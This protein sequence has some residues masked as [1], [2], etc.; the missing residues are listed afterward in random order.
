MIAGPTPSTIA[1]RL[2]RLPFGLFHLTLT[3]AVLAG[4]AFDHM[5]QV[6]LSFVIPRYREE[7]GLS[8]GAASI[9]PATGLGMTFVGALFW[10]MVS[11]R[12]GRKVTLMITL[13]IFSTTMAVN[14]FAWSFPQLVVT[15]MVMG[16]GVGGAIPLSFTLLAEYTPAMY[17]GMVMVLVGIL[18]LVGGYFI[19]S[20]SAWLLMDT[21]GWRS[22][23]LVGLAPAF[24]LPVI[25]WLVPE[26]PR[27]LLARGRTGEALR[28]V[29][30]LESRAGLRAGAHLHPST[31][32]AGL[33][34]DPPPAL[35]GGEGNLTLRG[36]GRLWHKT[37]RRR[38][39]MLWTYAYAF[40]FFTFGFLTW[41]PTVLLRAG[42]EEAQIHRY[43]TIMDLLAIPSA[44]LTALL[45]FYWSTKR[46]LI[47]YP[48]VAGLAMLALSTLVAR[49]AL[50][51][52]SLLVVGG[53]VFAF[54]TILL[55]IFGPYSTEVYPTEIRGTGS[56]WATGLSRVGA[57]TGIPVG[58]MLLDSGVPLFIHQIVFGVPLLVGALIM[59][60]L[61][62]ETRRRPLEE[63][64]GLEPHE[65]GGGVPED[66]PRA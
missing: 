63:I 53:V 38:T 21:Y 32:A 8:P 58:G 14:G 16:F 28:I 33:S 56:G 4:L 44:A 39:F 57:L 19:A 20:G 51:V 35:D 52:A 60:V 22:L 61:G 27:Y 43:A 47:L 66:N 64:A 11:D 26:S 45:F 17:R 12:I 55:G 40:G 2:D 1:E 59:A 50:T 5:D 15:C 42:F 31:G 37:Y 41:L 29:E 18:S 23:F 49:N 46:T 62:M 24:L 36:I 54:G 3:A 30:H 13:A 48:A 34:P 9:N 6:V 25:A 65:R 7:W 10:G